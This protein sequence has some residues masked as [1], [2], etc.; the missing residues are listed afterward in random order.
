MEFARDLASA[1]LWADSLERSLARRGRPRR[2]S[3]A[4]GRLTAE[5]DLAD[6]ETVLDSIVY[7]RARRAAS[8][9][10][11]FNV[12]AVGGASVLALLAATTLPSLAAA[13]RRRRSRGSCSAPPAGARGAARCTGRHGRAV[14]VVRRRRRDPR[15]ASRPPTRVP[16][17]GHQQRSRC[18][19]TSRI[20]THVLAQRDERAH[21]LGDDDG[22]ARARSRPPVPSTSSPARRGPAT[23][24]GARPR[25]G[26]RSTAPRS[27]Q[28]PPRRR[29]AR[30]LRQDRVRRPARRAAHARR[31]DRRRARAED[32]RGDPRLPGRARPD[33]RRRRRTADLGRARAA[34]HAAQRA[35]H[36]ADVHACRGRAC[37]QASTFQRARP[38][39]RAA[40]ADVIALQQQA[41]HRPRR[42]VRRGD[43][44]RR[45]GLP[46]RPR[47]HM[48]TASWA[49]RPATALG[50]RR[51]A[52]ARRPADAARAGGTADRRR[53]ARPRPRGDDTATTHGGGDD[54]HHGH[55]DRP[56]RRPDV[57]EHAARGATTPTSAPPA[58]RSSRPSTRWS[59]PATRSRRSP[60][61]GA[62]VTARG[63]QPATTARARSPTCCTPPAC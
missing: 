63:S 18:G 2:A 34:E 40:S 22:H 29:R 56:A 16:R 52:D 20:V 47:P 53:P 38:G 59:R 14:R 5:R 45:R 28:T 30:R 35:A 50:P 4:L 27:R 43:A 60:T 58:D 19:G 3:L 11:S 21:G 33:R 25:R 1:D 26:G 10:S 42:H 36:R 62:A 54:R 7:W 37:A 49:R 15:P 48:P 32:R 61:S 55:A 39:A 9:N 31:A 24:A 8:A 12:P 41:R 23:T 44:L 46:D 51:R 6:G 13:A 17:P 57:D